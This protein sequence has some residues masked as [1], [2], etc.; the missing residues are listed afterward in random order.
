[1]PASV[2]V[3]G[4]VAGLARGT[5]PIM[6]ACAGARCS[7]T[8]SLIGPAKHSTLS[9]CSDCAAAESASSAGSAADSDDVVG[10]ILV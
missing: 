3:I 8:P 1:M 5:L 7:T 4:T 10:F 9:H 6:A 2:R